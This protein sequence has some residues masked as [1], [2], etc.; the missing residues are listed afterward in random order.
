MAK[1]K[2]PMLN[3][4]GAAARLGISLSLVHKLVDAGKLRAYI[5]SPSGDLVE[6]LPGAKKQGAGLFFDE[7]DLRRFREPLYKA[8][9]RRYSSVERQ[10]VMRLH[11]LGLNN[12]EVAKLT[13]VSYQTVA[14]WTKQAAQEHESVENVA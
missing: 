6:R 11:K 14:N 3:A 7:D 4:K 13:G 8:K 9:G 12:R 1:I 10:E 5:Y 2:G